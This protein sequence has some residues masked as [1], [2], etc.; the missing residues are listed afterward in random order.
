MPLDGAE[1]SP[2]GART[3][4]RRHDRRSSSRAQRIVIDGRRRCLSLRAVGKPRQAHRAGVR[5]SLCARSIGHS[6]GTISGD[7]HDAVDGAGRNTQFA[8]GAPV[9]DHG[10]HQLRRTHD[11]IDRTGGDAQRASDARGFVDPREYGCFGEIGVHPGILPL[12]GC[13]SNE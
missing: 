10:M 11:R 13:G 3:G 8:A 7:E 1:A 6:P 12:P 2:P 9:G 4:E 5:M